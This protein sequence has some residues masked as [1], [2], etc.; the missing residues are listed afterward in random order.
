MERA[1]LSN[2]ESESGEFDVQNVRREVL[3]NFVIEEFSV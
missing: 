3:Y 1:Y 2:L